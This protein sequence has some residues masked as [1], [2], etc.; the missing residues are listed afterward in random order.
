MILIDYRSHGGQLG[1][2]CLHSNRK[3]ERITDKE[4]GIGLGESFQCRRR[5]GEMGNLNY[6]LFRG[7]RSSK[8]S[9]PS[10]GLQRCWDV[11]PGLPREVLL[12]QG[13]RSPSALRQPHLHLFQLQ[14]S[15][16]PKSPVLLGVALNPVMELCGWR[17]GGT[18]K[19]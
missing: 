3:P 17:Q 2:Q 16:S 10:S 8:T 18:L 1:H 6:S 12:P 13:L 9:L 14:T 4:N 19:I 5:K 15:T 11:A 7:I